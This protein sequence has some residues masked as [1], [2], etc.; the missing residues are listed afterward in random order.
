MPFNRQL[1]PGQIARILLPALFPLLLTGCF[2]KAARQDR[3]SLSVFVSSW[4][5]PEELAKSASVVRD[6]RA[7]EPCLW[8]VY[9]NVLADRT[10]TG[11]SE[12]T[13]QVALLNAAGVDAVILGPEWLELEQKHLRRLI[14]DSR[15]YVL[16]ANIADS[17]GET[18]GYPFMLK[19]FPGAAIGLCG[20]WLD[21]TD[22]RF[23]LADIDCITPDFSVR[24]LLPLMRPAA[25]VVGVGV[26]PGAEVPRWNADFVVGAQREDMITVNPPTQGLVRVSFTVQ[27]GA[28]LQYAAAKPDMETV[29][30]DSLARAAIDSI[31]AALDTA[32]SVVIAELSHA[33]PPS[34]LTRD[35]AKE[36]LGSGID[37]FILD[38]P[39]TEDSLEQGPVT[40]EMLIA[41]LSSPGRPALMNVSGSEL[42]PLLGNAAVSVEWRTGLN[43][44]KLALDRQY[45]M[46][47]TLDFLSRHPDLAAKH[48]YELADE[49]LWRVAARALKET[50]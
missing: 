37:G 34:V 26:R 50:E 7:D 29:E 12:G 46:A 21:S 3:Q 1:H 9:G 38:S 41:R 14:A 49:P 27:D 13:A 43:R 5:S 6:V 11:L 15:F 17:L 39:F 28:I 24:K 47:M 35:A 25:D 10:W 20:V 48:R 33:Q 19:K 45:R 8:L 40:R 16:G 18:T 31:Q 32:G 42:R 23:R 36:A 4:N 44:Q 2:V 22:V 30:P